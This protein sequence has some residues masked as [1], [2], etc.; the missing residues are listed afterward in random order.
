MVRIA[1]FLLMGLIGVQLKT[2]AQG[3]GSIKADAGPDQFTCDPNLTLQLQGNY[4]GVPDKYYWTPPNFLSDPNS[5]DPTVTAPP[6]KYTFTFHV[7]AISATNLVNNGNFESGNSGFTHEYNYGTPGGTFGPGWLSVGT[8]PLAYNG[9]WTP[10]G[11]H[12]T[13]SGNQ[14][15]VDGHTSANAKVWCQN[16]SVTPGKTYA[17]RFYV[18]SVYPVA[19]ANLT[20][21]ANNTPFGN[22]QA[23]GLCDWQMFEACFTATTASVELCIRETTGV[24]F[25]ND[26]TIDDISLHE[27]CMDD[28]EVIVEIVDLKAAINI[29]TL[30]KCA[31]DIFDLNGLGSSTGPNIQYMWR[32]DGG[33]IISTNGIT[34]KAQGGGTY[35]LKV[36]YRNGNVRCE[37]EV[38]LNVEPSEDLEATL[39][40]EGIANCSHDTIRL[41]G[42]VLNG[43]GNFSYFWIPGNK[44]VKGQNES[45][46]FVVEAGIY[47]LVIKDKDSGCETELQDVVVSDTI[48]PSVQLN[49][50][51]LIN[52]LRDTAKILGMPF[53][54]G[55][56]NYEWLLP[57]LS[58]I[59]NKNQIN[60]TDSG[61]YKLTIIDKANKCS[62]ESYW[63]VKIDTTPPLFDIGPN[64]F[65]DCSAPEFSV[66]PM[67][68]VFPD[69]SNFN[70][71]LPGG[72]QVN[73]RSF[74]SKRVQDSGWVVLMVINRLNGCASS[75]SLFVRDLRN[76]PAV[77][78]GQTDT[79][80]CKEPNLFLN[81]SA[82]TDSTRIQWSTQ[83]GNIV[84]GSNTLSPE[85]NH[86]GWY[87]IMVTDTV[88]HCRNVDS[89]FID[90]DF[91]KPLVNTGP[92][93]IFTC[94]DSIKLLDASLSNQGIN[95][96]YLW[97]TTNGTIVSGQGSLQ[98]KVSSPGTYL[99]TILDTTNGCSDTASVEVKPDFSAP[100]GI[101]QPV[102]TLTCLSKNTH[103]IANAFSPVGNPMRYQWTADAG[104]N[105]NRPTTLD[106]EVQEAGTYT[107][108]IYDEV[109][110]C[111]TR[112]SV[113]VPIDTLAP[114]AQA[115]QDRVWNCATISLPLDA[116]SSSGNHPL[117]F[118]WSTSNGIIS[119]NRFR[120]QSTATS[121]G[122]YTLFVID[123]VTHCQGFDTVV[124]SADTLKPIAGIE[125]P[126]TITCIQSNVILNG[127]LSTSG[128]Q[129][130]YNWFTSDG[131]LSGLNGQRINMAAKPGTYTMIISDTLNFCSDTQS[132]EVFENKVKPVL[133]KSGNTQLNCSTLQTQLNATTTNPSG[134]D[135]YTWTTITGKIENN[136]MQASINVSREAWYYILVSN[137]ENGCSSLDSIR[138]T[139]I[140]DLKVDAGLSATLTCKI[141]SIDLQANVF[142]GSGNEQLLWTTSGGSILTNPLNTFVRVDKPGTY[143]FRAYNPN[144]GCNA[145][146][147]VEILE[148]TNYPTHA[149]LQIIPLR[150]PGD[151]W[152]ATIGAIT[153]G[154]APLKIEFQGSE[155][156]GNSIQGSQAG[157]Y[158]ILIT[159]KFGCE[160]KK[161]F[162]ILPVAGVSMN[163]TPYIKINSGDSY[164][165]EPVFSIPNDSIG[166]IQWTPTQFLS[167]TDCPN[168]VAENVTQDIEYFCTVTDHKGCLASARIRIEVIKRNIW[169]PN[170]FSP[171]GD[172][173]N[174]LFFPYIEEGSFN[175]IRNF[176]IFDRWGNQVFEKR[177]IVPDQ[178]H[179]GWDGN[180][181]GNK[182]LP[183]VYVYVL[184][185]E[186]KNGDLQLFSGDVT[187]LR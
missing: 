121:P 179:L 130:K 66:S 102:D 13:G 184:Q 136:P 88:N 174:D 118:Q 143:F 80:N 17:F 62:T 175:Q 48:K 177:S 109:N 11:D 21:T 9:A 150:C 132:V 32:S 31:S 76:I 172:Q 110:G 36:I 42:D 149:E 160:L 26:F 164:S 122:T 57:D 97:S 58:Q 182:T 105:I 104:Q 186:W 72:K 54:T 139:Q 30:P 148:N 161:D 117:L 111:S 169:F 19:P 119:G 135:D 51:T 39:Q 82:K 86:A 107:L 129:F 154:E 133:L 47:R 83:T 144:N 165:I 159:D 98:L 96:L 53:D 3:C 59:K 101:I 1:L 7:E 187:L 40:V 23:A 27:K 163:L 43:S 168:P 67:G 55:R 94:A 33:K 74:T 155:I 126:D 178:I 81:A 167:C 49:G 180:S 79:L 153:G 2:S 123:S 90:Q 56:F 147:S 64:G 185:L 37:K 20:A 60:T 181:N 108:I 176:Q 166:N 93:L 16:V 115:G 71:N 22:V 99:L 14:L 29:P 41:T 92:D 157:N 128:S 116:S 141:R 34:A 25:G 125:L 146:D 173:I 89:V 91:T 45:T 18:Q 46:A 78:A 24:G 8:N 151:Q 61:I 65:I 28:D 113:Y 142:S 75:D 100:T 6:G 10:C 140:N 15:I 12:T 85:V 4:S 69:S 124:V 134:F 156:I 145:I 73:E 70:W 162:S 68:N 127:N 35:Y 120:S 50:D 152:S 5:L 114:N 171:N 52:C 138:V 137:R 95:Y 38:D 106:A 131:L 183:G 112:L 84:K 63:S 170:A 103:L 77:S 44:I 158:Q 87:F